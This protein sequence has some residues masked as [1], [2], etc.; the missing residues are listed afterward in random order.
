MN[1]YSL[2]VEQIARMID[3]AML[4]PQMTEGEVIEG[5]ALAKKYK[6]A[7]V[8]VRPYDV[9]LCTDYLKDTEVSISTVIGFPHGN[10]KTEVKL[11]EAEQAIKDG[12]VELDMVL[13]IGKIKSSSYHYVEQEVQALIDLT[14]RKGIILKVIFENNYLTDEEIINCCNICSRQQVDLVK[15]STGFASQGPTLEGVK[16][17]K[18]HVNPFTGIKAAGGIKT[19]DNFLNFYHAGATR[20]GTSSTHQIL[21]EAR[22]RGF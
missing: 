6:T 20:L 7:T 10:S 13:P 21:E 17:M 5:C 12:A 15:T 11:Y 19:L 1:N 3:H 4:K 9:S 2:T 18:A 16:L 8:C 22:Q 14:K